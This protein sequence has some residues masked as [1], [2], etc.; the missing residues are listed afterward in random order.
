MAQTIRSFRWQRTVWIEQVPARVLPARTLGDSIRVGAL[1]GALAGLVTA[2]MLAE[3]ADLLVHVSNVLRLMVTGT[4]AG[5]CS[6]GMFASEASS[7]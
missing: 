7:S 1:V 5:A 4:V 6:A 3:P 2:A